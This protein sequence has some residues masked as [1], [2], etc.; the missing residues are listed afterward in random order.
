MAH[1]MP[2]TDAQM[3]KIYGVELDAEGNLYLA[4]TVNQVFRVVYK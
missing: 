2:A 1:D 3:F 4:D